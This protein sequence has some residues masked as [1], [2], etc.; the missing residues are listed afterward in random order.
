MVFRKCLHG[1]S[2]L[3]TFLTFCNEQLLSLIE[4]T[5]SQWFT[6][7]QMF[8]KTIIDLGL[9][10]L[11]SCFSLRGT[12]KADCKHSGILP[13]TCCGLLLFYKRGY[14]FGSI[15]KNISLMNWSMLYRSSPCRPVYSAWN[16]SDKSFPFLLYQRQQRKIG[17]LQYCQHIRLGDHCFVYCLLQY[18]FPENICRAGRCKYKLQ[19]DKKTLCFFTCWL[20][21]WPAC[22]S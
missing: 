3:I 12:G 22:W 20:L 2:Q 19:V 10:F 6:S 9:S 8:Q 17:Y 21:P 7:E 18:V 15:K 11:F 13:H 5:M 14:L 16:S 4:I 1:W